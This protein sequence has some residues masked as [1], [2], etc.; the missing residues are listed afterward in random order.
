MQ[1]SAVRESEV[2]RFLP[3]ALPIASFGAGLPPLLLLFAALAALLSQASAT[4]IAGTAILS[5]IEMGVYAGLTVAHNISV[6]AALNAMVLINVIVA[7]AFGLM[8]YQTPR[9]LPGRQVGGVLGIA[10]GACLDA[11]TGG[12]LFLLLASAAAVFVDLPN[13]TAIAGYLG[14]SGL[15]FL[16]FTGTGGAA[17][18]TYG[19]TAIECGLCLALG[20]AAGQSLMRC[21]PA[22]QPE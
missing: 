9:E 10:A 19:T 2:P 8:P 12:G 13:L 16:M 1:Y 7:V 6:G 20:C 17:W 5:G 14:G 22:K 3:F 18:G 21:F 11:V 4:V 15:I